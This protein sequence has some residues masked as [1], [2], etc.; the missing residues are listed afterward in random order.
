M[1]Y[2]VRWMPAAVSML[3]QI[4]IDADSESRREITESVDEIESSLRRTPLEV[5]ESREGDR[6]IAFRDSLGLEFR[7][8]EDD[9]LVHIVEVWLIRHRQ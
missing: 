8:S 7:V 1:N 9:R 2:S 4:W 3:S 5:G 6:R